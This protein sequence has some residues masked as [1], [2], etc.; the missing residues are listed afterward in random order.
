MDS[1]VINIIIYAY[2]EQL[3]EIGNRKYSEAMLN[4]IILV[5]LIWQ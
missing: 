3:Q 1:G 4:S 5:Q 2:C